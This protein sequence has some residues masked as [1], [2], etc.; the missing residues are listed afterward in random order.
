[1]A[2]MSDDPTTVDGIQANTSTYGLASPERDQGT[3][4]RCACGATFDTAEA[5]AE[6][7]WRNRND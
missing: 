6:H 4:H 2:T 3:E 7:Q 5:L 1:M